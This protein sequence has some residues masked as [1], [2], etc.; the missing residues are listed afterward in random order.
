[1]FAAEIRRRRIHHRSY[2]CWRWHLDQVFARMNGEMFCLWRTIDHEGEV[3]EVFAKKRRDRKAA[4]K[5][6]KPT[7][8]R[9]IR[10]RSMVSVKPVGKAK[11]QL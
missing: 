8:K 4:L 3:L 1:M 10:P 5:F 9:Y 11:F 6:L 7:I 2:S